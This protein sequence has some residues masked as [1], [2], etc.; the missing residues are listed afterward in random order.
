MKNSL[1]LSRCSLTM[2]DYWKYDHLTEEDLLSEIAALEGEARFFASKEKFSKAAALEAEVAFLGR[3]LGRKKAEGLRREQTSGL[4]SIERS[5]AKNSKQICEAWDEKIE[6][7][8]RQM[9]AALARAEQSFAGQKKSLRPEPPS[10]RVDPAEKLKSPALLALQDTMRRLVE[11]KKYREAGHVKTLRD[12][13]RSALAS[14]VVQLQSHR[15]EA[16]AKELASQ[17]EVQ[18]RAIE[19]RFGAK[20]DRY[21]Q[22][23]DKEIQNFA[24]FF[25]I[26]R[27]KT[28]HSHAGE[29]F[30]L[31]KRASS[32]SKPG[33]AGRSL[34]DPRP[35][36]KTLLK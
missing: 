32:I 24:N 6:A 14:G 25:R 33:A 4:R 17:R 12:R 8:K 35:T 19:G 26:Q 22:E 16:K 13:E 5:F 3:V 28:L 2:R 36:R 23:R 10:P 31:E 20:I 30:R 18:T 27:Q 29:L 1:S 11:Q 15:L 7:A 21:R 9:A 34:V